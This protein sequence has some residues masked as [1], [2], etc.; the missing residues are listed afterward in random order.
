MAIMLIADFIDYLVSLQPIVQFYIFLGVFFFIAFAWM[1]H[2]VSRQEI[3][4]RKDAIK[5]LAQSAIDRGLVGTSR[6]EMIAVLTHDFKNDSDELL[7]DRAKHQRFMDCLNARI[8]S[9]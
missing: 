3:A 2:D 6:K 5:Y 9:R 7:I 1:A 4:T 8:A